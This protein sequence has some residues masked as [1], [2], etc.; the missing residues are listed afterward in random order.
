[1]TSLTHLLLMDSE[2]TGQIPR[3]FGE[4]RNLEYLDLERNR[5]TGKI[6]QE[7]GGLT[8]LRGNRLGG[9]VHAVLRDAGTN[10]WGADFC[11]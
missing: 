1:M 2:L 10:V 9:C 6:P 5:L 7:L 3:Q 4:L 11:P 8:K